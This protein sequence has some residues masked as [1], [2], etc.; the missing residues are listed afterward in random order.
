MDMS[1]PTFVPIFRPYVPLTMTPIVLGPEPSDIEGRR[2]RKA[3]W[4]SEVRKVNWMS[5]GF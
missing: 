4:M 2:P 5:E 3:D 1:P